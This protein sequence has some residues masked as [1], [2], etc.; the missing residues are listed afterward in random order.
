MQADAGSDLG[1][2]FGGH[3]YLAQ[4]E[5]ELSQLRGLV[6]EAHAAGLTDVA[7]L[8]PSQLHEICRPPGVG[9]RRHVEPA[10]RPVPTS[11]RHRLLRAA[12]ARVGRRF[13]LRGEGHPHPRRSWARPGLQLSSSSVACESLVVA[14]GVWTP[15]LLSTA[16]V[17]VPIMAVCLSEG[18]T[19]PVPGLL[20]GGVRAV[21]FGG[22]QRPNGRI[23][24]SAGLDARVSHAVSLYDSLDARRWTRRFVAHR[25]SIKLS[26]D[27]PAVRTQIRHRTLLGTA[28]VP[29]GQ[30][31]RPDTAQLDAAHRAMGGI[32]PDVASTRIE[33][34]WAGRIDMSLDGQPII[35]NT[36][37]PTGLVFVTGLSGH[38]LTLGPVIGEIA[39]DLVSTGST[40]RPIHP[41]RLAR[42]REEAVPVP[43]KTI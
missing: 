33:R 7:L 22:R 42:F 16:G 35:D 9:P 24:L 2:E 28:T 29:I 5:G 18:E 38:G 37:G 4:H 19:S 30:S 1:L 14:G 13:R 17:R 39:A 27:W 41:F 15:H 3:V 8:E 25:R 23:V 20:R 11:R 21:G 6:A 12:R 31:P 26:V 36:A 43:R 32:F 40:T 34:A 10:G